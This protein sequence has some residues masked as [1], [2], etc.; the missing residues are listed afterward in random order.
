MGTIIANTINLLFTALT[1]VIIARVILSWLPQ[2]MDSSFGRAIYQ[3]SEPILR[4]I[5]NMLPRTGMMDFSP[6]VALVIL[7]ILQAI[8]SSFL[9]Q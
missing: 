9:G 3:I 4:P 5:R 1:L 2:Y 7:L 8:V 6:M